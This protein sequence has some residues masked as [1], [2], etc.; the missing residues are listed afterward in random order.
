MRCGDVEYSEQGP[1]ST[2]PPRARCA[3]VDLLRGEPAA[4]SHRREI[5]VDARY[6]GMTIEVTVDHEQR[7]R[8]ARDHLDG[9]VEIRWQL[10]PRYE[11]RDRRLR[12]ADEHATGEA[13]EM[14]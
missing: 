7:A 8:R 3:G 6:H 13:R 12:C 14:G 4:R 10:E 1:R 11:L 2:Q 5:D 9:P